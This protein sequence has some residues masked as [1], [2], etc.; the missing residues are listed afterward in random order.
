MNPIARLAEQLS[1]GDL[2]EQVTAVHGPYDLVAPLPL[3][4]QLGRAQTV[5]WFDPCELLADDAR[6]ELRPEFR[7]RQRGGGWESKA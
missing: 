5:H 2:L 3:A 6:S 1:L 7:R 4:R